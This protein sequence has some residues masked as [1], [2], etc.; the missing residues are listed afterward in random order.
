[1]SLVR[2]ASDRPVPL[3]GTHMVVL[4][5][6]KLLGVTVH[7][8]A[9]ISPLGSGDVVPFMRPTAQSGRLELRHARAALRRSD[10]FKKLESH[11]DRKRCRT[12]ALQVRE[13]LLLRPQTRWANELPE[14]AGSLLSAESCEPCSP[15]SY[16]RQCCFEKPSG[17]PASLACGSLRRPGA[18]VV[19]LCEA[20]RPPAVA[21]RTAAPWATLAAAMLCCSRRIARALYAAE[22]NFPHRSRPWPTRAR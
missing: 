19:L 2:L 14:A 18:P 13:Q 7:A 16:L 12:N 21:C 17:R 20:A 10:V 22:A 8:P 11:A 4:P 15:S 1:M 3:A 5:A 9:R 6:A